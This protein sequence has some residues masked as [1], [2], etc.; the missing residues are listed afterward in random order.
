MG[1]KILTAGIIL[2]LLAVAMPLS[3]AQEL[4]I[5]EV[6]NGGMECQIISEGKCRLF[7]NVLKIR[8][9][10]L[11]D[12]SE[13]YTTP[14]LQ[15]S[16]DSGDIR[17]YPQTCDYYYRRG[18]IC[19]IEIQPVLE[20][21]GPETYTG[22]FSVSI[23]KGENDT[24]FLSS[25]V[26]GISIEP[27]RKTQIVR[28]GIYQTNLVEMTDSIKAC[29]RGMGVSTGFCIRKEEGIMFGNELE[30]LNSN[31]TGLT[32]SQ[33]HYTPGRDNITV[34]DAFN[35]LVHYLESPDFHS[36]FGMGGQDTS[37]MIYNGL[38]FYMDVYSEILDSN[39]R[40]EVY[41]NCESLDEKFGIIF[42]IMFSDIYERD[43]S[44]PEPIAN[45]EKAG[46][47]SGRAAGMAETA[48][49]PRFMIYLDDRLLRDD[50]VVCRDTEIRTEYE[51]IGS[52]GI[53]KIHVM[54][55]GEQDVCDTGHSIYGD[56][57]S[58]TFSSLEFMCNENDLP[59]DG[60]T[61]FIFIQPESG[62]EILY[63]VTYREQSEMCTVRQESMGV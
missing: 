44:G 34:M 29:I 7:D 41:S 32:G 15:L 40:R 10:L 57:G 39:L 51:N 59:V 11:T 47:F 46:Y 25:P 62:G 1:K 55:P 28:P 56:T 36:L 26:N 61:Y 35:S 3:S 49:K 13:F 17:A 6:I 31:F 54:G 16:G 50:Y 42:N 12:Y 2:I 24:E 18:I 5:L 52:L 23:R 43:F 45:L 8:A 14:D 63:P 60:E 21:S 58:R 38:V 19:S 9:E 4:E 22:T 53:D 48:G 27:V 37:R 20:I 30:S 33:P